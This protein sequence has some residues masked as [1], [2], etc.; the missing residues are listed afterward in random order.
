LV[1]NSIGSNGAQALSEALKINSTLADLS[2]YGNMIGDNGVQALAQALKIN[3]T[4]S[5]EKMVLEGLC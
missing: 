1:N 2:L 5:I 3:S 4:V